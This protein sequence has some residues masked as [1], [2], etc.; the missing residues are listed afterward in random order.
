[1]LQQEAKRQQ[2]VPLHAV[3]RR[4]SVPGLLS[5]R[6]M[7][8]ACRT[9]PSW[10]LEVK[11]KTVADIPSLPGTAS[12]FMLYDENTH[13]YLDMPRA[14]TEVQSMGDTAPSPAHCPL[15]HFCHG[16]SIV[17]TI[18]DAVLATVHVPPDVGIILRNVQ[19]GS[20]AARSPF[21]PQFSATR[22]RVLWCT[23]VPPQTPLLDY[24]MARYYGWITPRE[25]Q[26]ARVSKAATPKKGIR[27]QSR[28][29]DNDTEDVVH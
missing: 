27:A 7:L 5:G 3:S 10:H 1:M 26:S 8:W 18:S 16:I 24:H 23:L 17:S 21:D 19:F 2:K 13:L 14:V 15:R 22:G 29:D 20:F 6:Y 25:K 9:N 4:A 11:A 12:F 28:S